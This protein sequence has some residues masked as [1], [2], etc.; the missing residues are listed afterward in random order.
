VV[1]RKSEV[2]VFLRIKLRL[3][4]AAAVGQIFFEQPDQVEQRLYFVQ[5][6]SFTTNSQ[7]KFFM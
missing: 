5:A 7:K 3:S 1:D 4:Q 6:A 2:G